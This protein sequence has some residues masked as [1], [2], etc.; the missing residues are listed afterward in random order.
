MAIVNL[1]PLVG[2]K[3]CYLRHS[4]PLCFLVYVPS[5]LVVCV[6]GRP[7]LLQQYVWIH[8]QLIFYILYQEMLCVWN[9]WNHTK[10]PVVAYFTV[11]FPL[12]NF[13]LQTVCKKGRPWVSDQKWTIGRPGNKAMNFLCPSSFHPNFYTLQSMQNSL[14]EFHPF[15]KSELCTYFIEKYCAWKPMHLS[16][17]CRTW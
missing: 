14:P 3:L 1:I 10:L 4:V 7:L 2:H 17:T 13:S 15:T 5:S 12:S 9:D 11:G 6:G 16:V 8:K